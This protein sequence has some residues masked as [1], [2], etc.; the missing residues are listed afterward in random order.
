MSMIPENIIDEVADRLGQSE[1]LQ[2]ESIQRFQKEQ[3]VIFGYFFSEDFNAFTKEEKEYAL[4]LALSIFESVRKVNPEIPLV[5]E[6][7]FSEA[8]DA[9][10]E[11]LQPVTARR[12]RER[13]DIFFKDYA[14][15]DLLAFIEDALID[16]EEEAPVTKEGREPLF[17]LMKTIIDCL[18]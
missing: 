5:S 2:M 17:V 3:P 8:E 7:S 14:Q 9:N 10:W 15:E 4:F 18:T 11:K 6:K 12:F 16:D 1:E 13:M